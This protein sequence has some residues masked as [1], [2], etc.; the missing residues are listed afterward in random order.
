M[1]FS[2][3]LLDLLY[4]NSI[5]NRRGRYYG[6]LKCSVLWLCV[7]QIGDCIISNVLSV[8]LTD[9]MEPERPPSPTTGFMMP[10]VH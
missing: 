2:L 1:V 8:D 5:H 7:L 3:K 4:A 9:F 10:A 6:S